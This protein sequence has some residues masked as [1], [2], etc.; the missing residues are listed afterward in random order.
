MSASTPDSAARFLAAYGLGELLLD[1]RFATNEARVRNVDALDQLVAA[2]IAGHTLAENLE[3]VESNNLTAV[4]VQTIA[5]IERDPHWQERGL[6]HDVADDQGEVRMHHVVPRLSG[7]PGEIRWPGPRLGVHN[8]DVY[9]QE[10]DISSA[11]LDR[12]RKEGII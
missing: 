5:D 2:A 1:L 11:E 6:T 10:L 7:T 12:L 8:D 9:G 3:I 4:A